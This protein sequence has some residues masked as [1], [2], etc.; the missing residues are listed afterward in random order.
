MRREG[1]CPFESAELNCAMIRSASTRRR[2]FFASVR[3]SLR[4]AARLLRR[5]VR[6][7]RELQLRRA[8]ADMDER[9]MRD[10]G[11]PAEQIRAALSRRIPPIDTMFW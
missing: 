11:V 8:L 3:L 9:Q 4:R 1:P 5:W 6:L 10:I 2:P 7:R